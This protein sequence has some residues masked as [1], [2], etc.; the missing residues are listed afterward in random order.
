V[1]GPEPFALSVG[2]LP[3]LRVH[4]FTGHEEVNRLYAFD[5]V[6]SVA[7]PDGQIDR[8]ILGA[9]ASLYV[10]L[11]GGTPRA[12]YGVATHIEGEDSLA[13]GERTFH[14]RVS[15]ALALLERRVDTRI[16]Q[17]L[18]LV[19]VIDAV[20]GRYPTPHEFRLAAAPPKRAYCVQYSESDFAFVT[21]LLAEAGIFFW[22]EHAVAD[23]SSLEDLA[24]AGGA[25]A[26]E[27]L[28]MADAAS[29]YATIA[30]DDQLVFREN[31]AIGGM[32]LEE[33]HVTRFR[34]RSIVTPN[35]VALRD[36]DFARPLLDLSSSAA[37]VAP[38]AMSELEIYEHH[39]EYEET[40]VSPATAQTR[41]EQ[42]TA[43]ANMHTGESVCRRLFPGAT[44]ALSDHPVDRVN[45]RHVV[46]S[47]THT[48]ITPHAG[49]H[50]VTYQNR[51]TALDAATPAR[52][53]RPPRHVRQVM[54][55]AVVVGP[56]G[57]EVFTDA[58]GRVKVRFHWDR[59]DHGDEL[60]SCFLRVSQSW[61]GPGW[62]FQFIPRIGMEVV[63]TFLGGDPDRPLVTGCVYNALNPPSNI[64]PL[65]VARSGIRTRT[66]PGGGGFN[67][68]TFDDSAGAEQ[69]YLRAQRNLDEVVL[70]D[71][72]TTVGKNQTLLVQGDHTTVVSATRSITVDGTQT[73]TIGGNAALS[74][75]VDQETTTG[76]NQRTTVDGNSI[77]AV[78]GVSVS[79]HASDA[80][81]LIVG[82]HTLRVEGDSS[83]QIGNVDKPSSGEV[84]AYGDYNLAAGRVVRL[85][86]VDSIV[87]ECGDNKLIVAHDGITIQASTIAIKA[88]EK[89]S[90]SGKG[91]ALTL[92]DDAEI[93]A[94]TVSIRSSGATLTMADDAN[95]RSDSIKVESKKGVLAMDDDAKISATTV[96][97]LSADNAS[98]EIDKNASVK[99]AA[100]AL[101]KPADPADKPADESSKQAD[102]KDQKPETKPLSLRLIDPKL[103]PYK[104]KNYV[105]VVAGERFEGKTDGDGKIAHDVRKEAEMGSL[106]LW[107]SDYP[108][109]E[110][111]TWKL[112][113]EAEPPGADVPG[114]LLRLRNLGY[115][116]GPLVTSIDDNLR[117]ALVQFQRDHEIDGTGELD[118]PTLAKLSEV[119]GH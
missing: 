109:G 115:Y 45:A 18:T 8:A 82:D 103:E 2:D 78:T 6:A 15:P 118:G 70:V 66:L 111:V 53:P 7:D 36:Y 12:V 19:E 3:P 112:R 38:P 71:H 81:T 21:R 27:L 9:R 74:V 79:Q 100:V 37:P 116:L 119:H 13:D 114:A 4:S 89:A 92:G 80:L 110:R 96:K 108:T 99:G 61:A 97:L 85:R 65:D 77:T 94:K 1:S 35:K 91:P 93:V 10:D 84:Y 75:G 39:G 33:R 104:E 57:S 22:F 68:L 83:T 50:T 34:S 44:F 64:L 102:E 55:T 51:F 26:T 25:A 60:S 62:G 113:I 23:G 5:I 16:F 95:L 56:E 59:E 105:L 17:D 30:G 106:I 11:P 28:V 107:P 31:K 43:P 20:L 32:L 86:A 49:G 47:L 14:I 63:V 117:S 29:F 54:E 58:Y 72:S 41:L 42:H 98:V 76:G 48:G 69:V 67:E 52:P 40:D 90:M 46:T 24:S 87:L 88:S 101:G 73:V